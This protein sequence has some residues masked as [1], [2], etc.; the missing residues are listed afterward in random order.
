MWWT[1]APYAQTQRPLAGEQ[2]L[3]AREKFFPRRYLHS[4]SKK[5][6]P[7]NFIDCT[8]LGD[9]LVCHATVCLSLWMQYHKVTISKFAPHLCLSSC[10]TPN[11]I[12]IHAATQD[13]KCIKSPRDLNRWPWGEERTIN[14]WVSN[15]YK[16]FQLTSSSI[17][18]TSLW[19]GPAWRYIR[20]EKTAIPFHREQESFS[21]L[22]QG[23]HRGAW[24]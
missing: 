16:Y 7:L 18:T 10:L 22:D 17:S 11:G 20:A 23:G 15:L 12:P 2:E 24:P 19:T 1:S 9:A 3:E 5:A 13:V 8:W 4:F 14:K 21:S 6:N